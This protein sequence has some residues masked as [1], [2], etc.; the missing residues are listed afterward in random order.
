MKS[1]KYHPQ[2][3]GVIP[4]TESKTFENIFTWY[5]RYLF[6]RR[7]DRV[8]FH[9]SYDP[10]TLDTSVY[11]LNHYSWWDGLTPIL[12]NKIIFRQNMRAM[13]VEGQ[14]RK[15]PFFRKLGVFSVDKEHSRKSMNA[16]RYA[17]D[18]MFRE[19]ASLFIYPQG[20]IED[21]HIQAIQFESGVAWLY[22]HLPEVD[23]VP[24][25]T[26]MNTRYSEKPRLYILIGKPVK[27][28]LTGKE[29]IKLVLEKSLNNLRDE[30]HF[31]AEQEFPLWNRLI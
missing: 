8:Y 2:Y 6:K 27:T 12:I 24:I 30:V 15:F 10:G 18:S 7:F 3:P 25:A 19:K 11:F 20:K 23:F 21:E 28:P 14:L 13:M 5:L 17:A 1:L 26:S 16:L 29:E 22:Q 9:S 4:A 31:V